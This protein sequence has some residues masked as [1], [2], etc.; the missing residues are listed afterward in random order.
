LSPLANHPQLGQIV[1]LISHVFSSQYK[2]GIALVIMMLVL[3][4]KPQGLFK[5][6]M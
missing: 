2:A 3:L 6:T 5:G 1:G 4:V